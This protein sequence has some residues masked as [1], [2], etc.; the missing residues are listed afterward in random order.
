M[1]IGHSK[2][3]TLVE[4]VATLIIIALIAAVSGPR[5]FTI[6]A[7]QQQGFFDETISAVRYAQKLAVATDCN[8]LVTFTS[9]SFTLYRPAS[10]T[11]VTGCNTGPGNYSVQVAD[12]TGSAPTF[13]RT[14]PSGVTLSPPTGIVFSG[15]GTASL[16][17]GASTVPI[18]VPVTIS[19]GTRQFSVYGATGFVQRL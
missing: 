4:L 2:G 9:T 12:P 10:A 6:S 8:V 17:V 13:T 15:D 14:A 11:G 16:V 18:T 5:F 7:F 3:F 19:V 1:R